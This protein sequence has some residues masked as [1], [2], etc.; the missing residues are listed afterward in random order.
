MT[1]P[2]TAR[3]CEPPPPPAHAALER[4][5]S[6]ERAN[7]R[8]GPVASPMDSCSRSHGSAAPVRRAEDRVAQAAPMKELWP[9]EE[10]GR[11]R[12]R[13]APAKPAD[14]A[15]VFVGRRDEIVDDAAPSGG[16]ADEGERTH[17]PG[18]SPAVRPSIVRTTDGRQP[19][20]V[21]AI[22]VS[23]HQAEKAVA[24]RVIDEPSTSATSGALH[25]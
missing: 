23:S 12:R 20:G 19:R 17:A 3:R 5:G 24:T 21:L 7:P 25:H 10:V 9:C 13:F 14:R 15:L 18:P 22:W 8:P 2:G 11:G 16:E 1:R 6:A 4:A